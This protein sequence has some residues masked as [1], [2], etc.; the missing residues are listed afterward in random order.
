MFHLFLFNTTL[1][2]TNTICYFE[3]NNTK[4]FIILTFFYNDSLTY[5]NNIPIF[6]D[7]HYTINL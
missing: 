6:A 4:K 3:T 5:I 2:S 7:N 1:L